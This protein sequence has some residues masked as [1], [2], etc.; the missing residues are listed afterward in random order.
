MGGRATATMERYSFAALLLWACASVESAPCPTCVADGG[1]SNT[2]GIRETAGISGQNGG[3]AGSEVPATEAG[4]SSAAGASEAGAAGAAGT[5]CETTSCDD[6]NP[7]TMDDCAPDGACHHSPLAEGSSCDDGSPC[8]LND[9]CQADRCVGSPTTQPGTLEASLFVYGAELQGAE[10][11][12][13]L[14]AFLSDERVVFADRLDGSGT[15]LSVVQRHGDHLELEAQ[16]ITRA[17]LL[18]EPYNGWVWQSHWVTHLLA[19]SANRFA[20]AELHGELVV[21]E[22]ADGAISVLSR[23]RF[24]GAHAGSMMDAVVSSDGQ[25]WACTDGGISRYRIAADGSVEQRPSLSF[26]EGSL[27]CLSLAVA[28]D[29]Q[30]VYASTPSGIAR[31]TAT[32]E[33]VIAAELVLPQVTGL[34]LAADSDQLLV[35]RVG[36]LDAFGPAE[37]Y[38][39]SDQQL[40]ASSQQTRDFLPFAVA[41]LQGQAVIAWDESDDSG[42]GRAQFL[43]W[44]ISA[45]PPGPQLALRSRSDG[46]DD[47]KPNYEPVRARG[48]SLLLQPWRRWLDYSQTTHQF[49]EV[50]GAG[51][52]SLRTLIAAN[53]TNAIAVGPYAQQAIDLSGDGLRFSAGGIDQALATHSPLQL[54]LPSRPPPLGGFVARPA[55]LAQKTADAAVL[56]VGARQNGQTSWASGRLGFGPGLLLPRE[57]ALYQV[58]PEGEFG[59]AFREFDVPSAGAATPLEFVQRREFHLNLGTVLPT[60]GELVADVDAQRAQA[61]ILEARL[62]NSKAVKG[63]RELLWIDWSSGSLRILARATLHDATESWLLALSQDRLLVFDQHVAQAYAAKN[64]S[65]TLL[66]T[67]PT[68]G[69][70]L[71]SV[72]ALDGA[73]RAY[74]SASAGAREELLVFDYEG[75]LRSNFTL[76]AAGISMTEVGDRLLL[77]TKASVHRFTASCGDVEPAEL[78]DYPVLD[79]APPAQENTA[80]K[81][82]PTCQVWSA[83]IQPGDVDRDGCVDSDDVALEMAC[84][85]LQVDSCKQSILADLDGNGTVDDYPMVLKNFGKGCSAP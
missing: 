67:Q 61:V 8:T 75:K 63:P 30:T 39:I 59:F 31:W 73:R 28:S 81:A 58:S 32:A 66:S 51:H 49:R 5:Q 20:L 6:A 46:L 40:L 65:L 12:G 48:S 19:I 60:R 15:V 70:A 72:L 45:S 33:D 55:P 38:R 83:P 77:A 76:P 17:P 84:Y 21:Y 56:V 80:C 64:G 50:T 79:P 36:K 34:A 47:W 37:L 57:D 10:L 52:G 7:C 23:Y 18:R 14:S 11:S 82:L 71:H 35:H 4:S 74:V 1:T 24:P 29:G 26:A 53:E 3:S 27:D 2:A 78:T 43:G 44:P 9:V 42:L 69:Y 13:G 25:I 16:A 41:L 62:A 54:V 22:V 68:E 85:G